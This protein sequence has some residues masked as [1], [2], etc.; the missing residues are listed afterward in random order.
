MRSLPI[1]GAAT[2]A[3]LL[4][5]TALLNVLPSSAWAEPNLAQAERAVVDQTN[6]F[7]R[8]QGLS[9]TQP[10][11]ALTAAA[12]GFAEY[13]ARTDQYGHE[14]DGRQP[15]QRAKAA[16]YDYCI[17]SENIALR[18][19]SNGFSTTELSQGFAQG[20]IDSP[21][22]R[23]NMLAP[24]VTDTAVAIA[25]SPSSGRYYA[26]QMF[27]RPKSMSMRFSLS[28]ESRQDVR[29]L[30]DGKSYTLP[31]R[32]TSTHEQCTPPALSVQLP[33]QA[34]AASLKP[35]NG[36]VYRITPDRQ[37]GGL[38]IVSSSGG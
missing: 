19:Q 12:R 27:G 9:P 3:S 5:A 18:Y 15:S 14:A 22:H 28:N 36:A 2:T 16:G 30:L 20:W 24:A 23:A 6:D 26:V 31:P 10:Q 37:S 13:M 4:L 17:V 21:G 32:A 33:G 35:T 8:S 7:R 34:L 29:Y 1:P 11:P 25:R 38:A